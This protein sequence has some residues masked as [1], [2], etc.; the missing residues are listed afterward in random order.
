MNEEKAW[1]RSKTIWGGIVAF[2]AAVSGLFG[3]DIDQAS[4]EALAVALTDAVAAIGAV[5]AI[6]GRLDAQTTIS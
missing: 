4:G 1:Y 6:V 2:V 5:V 3:I